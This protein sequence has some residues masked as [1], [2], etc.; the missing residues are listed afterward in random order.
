MKR[1]GMDK[2]VTVCGPHV[3][4]PSSVPENIVIK[5]VRFR[6]QSAITW[7]SMQ[8]MLSSCAPLYSL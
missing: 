1:V 3:S 5:D 2:C 8:V 4:A 7:A 6:N